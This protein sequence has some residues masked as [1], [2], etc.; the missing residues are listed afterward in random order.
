MLHIFDILNPVRTVLI[1][2]MILLTISF[3]IY[4]PFYKII[5]G[6]TDKVIEAKAYYAMLS[7]ILNMNCFYLPF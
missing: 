1:V 7:L 3:T 2:N 6:H 5:S 4:C